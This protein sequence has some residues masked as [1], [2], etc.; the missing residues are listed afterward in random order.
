MRSFVSFKVSVQ[1]RSNRGGGGILLIPMWLY[2]RSSF[3]NSKA[4]I[5]IYIFS[6]MPRIHNFEDCFYISYVVYGYEIFFTEDNN[7]WVLI[8]VFFF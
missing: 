8:L 5:H 4:Y 2:S 6:V 7:A 1:K 3:K